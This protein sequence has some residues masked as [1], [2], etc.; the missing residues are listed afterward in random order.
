MLSSNYHKSLL[1]SIFSFI[2]SCKVFSQAIIPYSNTST[3]NYVRTWDMFAPTLNDASIN[4]LTLMHAAQ[5]TTQY[6]DGLGRPLQT[7]LKQ[8]SCNSLNTRYSDIV[9]PIFYDE[10]GRE[11]RKYLPFVANDANGNTSIVDGNFKFNPFQQQQYF[12]S[13][14]NPTDRKSTRLNSS[15]DL[16][17]RMPSSA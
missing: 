10:H 11:K 5:Q 13:D 2:V 4:E 17:S 15:H 6:I 14:N 8:G 12:Y 3:I 7:V 16:A 1:V 9:N